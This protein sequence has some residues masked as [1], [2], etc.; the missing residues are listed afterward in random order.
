VSRPLEMTASQRPASSTIA[1]MPESN[2]SPLGIGKVAKTVGLS[3]STLR[4][5]EAAGLSTPQRDAWGRR[6]YSRSE[7][8]RLHE[9]K[10]FR[11]EEGLS[12]REIN[13]RLTERDGGHPDAASRNH[14]E[15][16]VAQRLRSMRSQLGLTVRQVAERTSLSASYVSS[17]ENGSIR[18][19]VSGLLKLSQAYGANI[20]SFYGPSPEPRRRLVRAGN[21]EVI[22]MGD[23]GVGVALL[24]PHE[25]AIELHFFELAPGASSGGSYQ[26]D[27]DEFWYVLAGTLGVWV[28]D[29]FFQLEAGDCLS[30]ASTDEHR[31]INLA[32]GV[33]TFLG[34]NTP[35][36]F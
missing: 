2:G 31:F 29:E 1:A 21:A 11:E 30:F 32:Q 8:K 24:T 35:S 5:W 19:S 20:L 36:T 10:R 23:P 25:G 14:T 17:V 4:A 26:H 18:P 13:Q 9:I 27:G 34:G 28:A 22:A 12:L 15:H 33:T 3:P 16:R 7:T 6:W